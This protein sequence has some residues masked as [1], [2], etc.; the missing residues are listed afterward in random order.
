M[1]FRE[2]LRFQMLG[3]GKGLAHPIHCGVSLS[4]HERVLCSGHI[5]FEL[6][7]YSHVSTFLLVLARIGV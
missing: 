5:L 2:G 7:R 6:V 4:V 1:G 3:E